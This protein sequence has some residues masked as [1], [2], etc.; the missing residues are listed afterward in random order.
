MVTIA[1]R[2]KKSAKEDGVESC[3][4]NREGTEKIEAIAYKKK[5]IRLNR[6][7][8]SPNLIIE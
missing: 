6:R 4:N 2:N 5:L 3:L 8:S 1:P 7:F